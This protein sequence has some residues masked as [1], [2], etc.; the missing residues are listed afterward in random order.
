MPTLE[1]SRVVPMSRPALFD[2]FSSPARLAE[3]SPP[4]ALVLEQGPER[5]TL[6][7]VCH[8]KGRRW[9]LT[10]RMTTEVTEICDNERIVQ[11]QRRGPMRR[12][13]HELT[14]ADAPGG[15]LLTDHFDY[16]PPG[17]LLGLTVTAAVLERDL[18]QLLE[19]RDRRML[20]TLS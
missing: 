12:W 18:R 10:Q 19:E 5:L 13:R 15:T 7:A 8:W 4:D 20:A 1:I 14:L 17:G 11:E 2:L 6:G 16:D 9:G 3:I